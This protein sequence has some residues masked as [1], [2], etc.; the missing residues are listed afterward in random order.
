L[1]G[2]KLKAN[3]LDLCVVVQ[4]SKSDLRRLDLAIQQ[5]LA[6]DIRK[7]LDVAIKNCFENNAEF[8]YWLAQYDEKKLFLEDG[9]CSTYDFLVRGQ[10]FSEG[11]AW[12]RIRVARLAVLQPQILANIEDGFWSFTVLALIAQ[13]NLVGD[14]VRMAL[15]KC[16]RKTKKEAERIVALM[17]NRPACKQKKQ[18][19]VRI[20]GS[21]LR[22]PALDFN[23]SA[24]EKSDFSRELGKRSAQSDVDLACNTVKDDESIDRRSDDGLPLNQEQLPND[25]DTCGENKIDQASI[26]G[27]F[28]E[29]EN[30]EGLT[31]KCDGQSDVQKSDGQRELIFR[32]SFDL[33]ES[34]YDRL[35]HA[36]TLCNATDMAELVSK[37]LDAYASKLPD[38]KKKSFGF[39]RTTQHDCVKKPPMGNPHDNL[40]KESRLEAVAPNATGGGRVDRVDGQRVNENPELAVES[41]AT[42]GGGLDRALGRSEKE[43]ITL[44]GESNTTRGE[45]LNMADGHNKKMNIASVALSNA[46]GGGGGRA[47]ATRKCGGSL[48]ERTLAA[49][50]KRTGA[51]DRSRYIPR[52]VRQQV[53]ERSGGTCGFVSPTTGRRCGSMDRLEFEH[54]RPF[55]KGG[56]HD[57]ENLM[58]L[59]RAHNQFQAE[60]QFGHEK[61]LSFRIVH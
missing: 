42:G 24:S 34:T 41:N 53:W 47:S 32:V 1:Q 3:I 26:S 44:A 7:M 59:C 12:R 19:T 37:L 54:I 15:T 21:K 9:Y 46:T 2:D 13:A 58:L 55:A 8:I 52:Q 39:G 5:N 23:S 18:D 29:T 45:V 22:E 6:V 60:R 4:N 40:A 36:K 16:Q 51:N 11:S 20:V 10:G 57:L 38:Y 61:M 49:V 48:E 28:V 56:S 17:Q 30:T 50:E 14:D 35:L 33:P 43:K 31:E 25:L 27:V